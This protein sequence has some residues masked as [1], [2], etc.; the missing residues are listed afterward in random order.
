MQPL[1]GPHPLHCWGCP[2]PHHL[3]LSSGICPPE[4]LPAAPRWWPRQP[5]TDLACSPQ[6]RTHPPHWSRSAHT[7]LWSWTG[8]LAPNPAGPRLSVKI[9]IVSNINQRLPRKWQS[10]GT[11]LTEF[12]YTRLEIQ[13]K[14]WLAPSISWG[15]GTK[16]NMQNLSGLTQD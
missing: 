4:L 7:P 3:H 8:C 6:Q 13:R 16:K 15:G 12:T 11:L 9:I 1:S 14:R 2:W 5:V 10:W